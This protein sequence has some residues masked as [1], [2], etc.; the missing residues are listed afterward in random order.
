MNTGAKL[1]KVA[2]G[3]G[4][5]LLLVVGSGVVLSGMGSQEFPHERHANLFPTCMGCHAGIPEGDAATAFP[6]D[7]AFCGGCHNGSVQPEIEWSGPTPVASNLAFR[8]TEHPTLDCTTC[9]QVPGGE[10]MEIARSTASVCLGCHAPSAE[11]HQAAGVDCAKC[12]VPIA[13]AL[14]LSVERIAAFP[15]PADH[16]SDDYYAA[17]GALTGGEADRCSVCHAKESCSRCHV[18]ADR[19]PSVRDLPSDDRVAGLVAGTP[20][21]WPTPADHESVEWLDTHGGRASESIQSCASCH[22]QES[23]A[24]CHGE[25]AER[26]A[27]GLSSQRPGGPQGAGTVAVRPPGHTPGFVTE[28]GT[29]ASVGLPECSSCHA[30]SFCADCHDGPAAPRFNVESAVGFHPANFV[31]RHGAEAFASQTECSSCHSTEVF[32]RDCHLQVGVGQAG[33]TTGGAFHNAQPGWLLSHG[34]AARQGLETCTS[35]HAQQSCL[36]CHSAKSGWRVSP[37]GPSFDPS[38]VSD[39]STMSCGICHFSFQLDRP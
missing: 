9:H 10:S 13:D 14:E 12:H 20:G 17:H 32:C 35:C 34:Q 28:H 31:T 26:L 16:E 18:N 15:R 22:V 1:R 4:G 33:T 19:L 27:A 6:V 5:A 38:R 25:E 29:A 3:I 21:V 37:H 39:R 23:C 11:E 24:T 2:I 36:K 30:E 8:H 7:P